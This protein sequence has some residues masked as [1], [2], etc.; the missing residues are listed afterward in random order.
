M[1][2]RRTVVDVRDD[3]EAGWVGDAWDDPE[4]IPLDATTP[5]AR[6]ARVLPKV[7]LGLALVM[8]AA[9]VAAG[10]LGWWYVHQVNPDGDPLPAETFTVH[11]LDDLQTTS[12]RLQEEG[13]IQNAR[14][15]RWYVERHGGL[16]IVAGFYTVRPLDHMGNILSVLRTPPNE[17]YVKVTFPEGYT[18]ARIGERLG[19]EVPGIDAERFVARATS[20][21]VDSLYLPDGIE[22]L[23]GL[24]FPDTYYVA[25]TE[26]ET[27]VTRRMVALMERV[28]RQEGLDDSAR[29]VGLTPYQTLIV[30]SMIEREAKVPEDRPKIARV[31][32]NRLFLGMPLQ[33]DATLLYG[34]D[35]EAPFDELVALDTPFNTYLHTG[36]PPTP[37]ANPGRASI[38]AALNPAPNPRGDDELCTDLAAD[39]PCFYLYYVLIDEDGHH[40]FAATL[41]QH[42]ANIAK[43]REA[44]VL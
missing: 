20:A 38:A 44:G 34:Q 11:E 33:I 32:L 35:P 16:E 4:W 14:V 24:L 6:R 36:L 23:E 18:V 29:L 3:A 25:G 10:V 7:V 21:Y 39:T 19:E 40:A 2:G 17:T 31:I 9:A 37:I 42:E 26:T 15:F 43:A 1:S 30:A 22:S 41:A 12:E 28:G 5:E 13:F 27:Q 8:A